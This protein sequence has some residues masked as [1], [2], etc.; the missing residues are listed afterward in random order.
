MSKGALVGYIVDSAR[1]TVRVV[2]D[3]QSVDLVRKQTNSIQMRLSNDR[4]RVIDGRITRELPAAT[5][6]L[7][8]DA[9]S[10]AA[11]GSIAT[12]PQ[13]QRLSLSSQFHFDI[14][15]DDSAPVPYLGQRVE[16]L[17]DHGSEPLFK[18]CPLC[19]DS[20]KTRRCW[21][22]AGCWLR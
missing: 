11:G 13:G 7:P 14:Q 15:P 5:D 1:V 8:S 3:Q 19:V 9:L 18:H 20:G 4:L 12:N 6:L 2:V 22:R 10:N 16:V 17:F 21:P